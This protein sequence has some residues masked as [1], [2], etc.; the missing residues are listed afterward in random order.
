MVDV[1]GA[2]GRA[3]LVHSSVEKD[4]TRIIHARAGKNYLWW[5]PTFPCCTSLGQHGQF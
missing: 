1:I 4:M 2:V 5:R 3:V